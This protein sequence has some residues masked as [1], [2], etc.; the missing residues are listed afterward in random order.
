MKKI[1]ILLLLP[2]FGFGQVSTF[3]WVNDFES[4]VLLDE[5]QNDD[6]DWWLAQG[7][8]S[9][10]NTGP[11]G[12]HTTGNG[13]YYYVESSYPG[14]PNQ[15][16]ITY[17]PTFDISAT[18]G[19]VLS[20]WYHMYGDAM[21]DLEIAVI[22]G[23]VYTPIDTISGNQGDQW[24][25]AYYPITAIDSFKIAFK[26]TTGA[27]FTSDICIDDL[28]VSDPYTII[29]GCMDTISSNY[30]STATINVGCIY[31]YGCVDPLA[32]NY[33]PW[34]NVNDGSCTQVVACSPNK[35]LVDIA[36]TLDNW[37]N[38]TSWLIYSATDTFAQVPT[39]TYDYTQTGQT[40]HT[41]VCI[42]VGDS[43]MFTLNDS[44]GD[45]IGGGSVVGGCLVTNLDCED[46]IF[47]LNPPNFGYT[48]SSNPYVSAACNNDTTIYG[49][50][51]ASYLEYDPLATDDDG[52]CLTFATYGCTDVNAYNYDPWADRML[53]TSPCTYDLILYD[54]GG[55]SWGACWLGVEQGDSLWQFKINGNGIYSQTFALTLNSYDEV[56]MYYF[57]I[58]TPQQNAQQLDIQTIQ[59]SFKL[60]NS[61]GIILYEGNNP[62]P[63]PNE[64]KLRNYKGALDI[65]S[66][67]PYCG[68]ECIP[69]IIGCMDVMAFNYNNLA[70]TNDTCYYNPGCTNVG[71]LEYYTQGFVADVDDGSC[72]TVAVFG[73]TDALA[74]NYDLLAN[75]DNGGCIP[76]ILG[77]M[78][79]LAFNYNPQANTSDTCIAIVYG[80][81]SSI[82]INYDP[83]ANMDDGSCIG[84][85]Y[86]CTDST[87]WNYSPSANADDGSCVSYIYGCMD[88]TMWNYNP[89]ANTDN[90]ACITFVYGC[91]DSTMFNYNPLANTNNDNCIPFI[92]GCTNPIALNYD[93]SANTDDFSCILSIYG[94][95]DSLAF[96]YNP[97][98]NVDNN[99]C[100]PVILGCT[101]PIALNYCDS[102]NTDDFSCVLPIYGCTDS[103]MF[104]YNPLAN[105]DNSSCVPFI[106][107]CT[108]P[109]M[110]NYNSLANTE[111]FSCISYIYGCMD[112]TALNYDSLANTDNESCITIVE[113]CMDQSAYNYDVTA[114]VSDSISCLFDAGCITGAGYPYWLNDPCYA[115]VVDIDDYCCENEWDDICQLTYDYCDGTYIGPLLKRTENEKELIMI[116]DLLGRP[117]KE[118]KNQLLFYIYDDGSVEKTI[119]K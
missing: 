42:P 14:Y 86:G 25:F 43:I 83:L 101:D 21:G 38:E 110:L 3:P 116:T 87:M 37:P 22:S 23:G 74:F 28:M 50:T 114:N 104:N 69:V 71:Y 92:Y 105:V 10:S 57:E 9:S 49:C 66:A 27:S 29:Y 78:Q 56:Y 7:P 73:C 119:K 77:C 34:A 4:Y 33:N 58:A 65:Y 93:A 68:D 35:S 72:N 40:I 54:D 85:T 96:N 52:S 112:S 11:S 111:D 98:A 109:S 82:A 20:F 31:Y 75:V 64:N 45:G 67:Q 36:I 5:D 100:L 53:L 32:T 17:T 76:V 91:V 115:W 55:D 60:E 106:F 16:F 61:Y 1:L 118:I 63:G 70:N 113:G 108:D 62:W 12:D 59:N 6:G 8:T 2:I 103:V 117:T 88:A 102:C 97:L 99:S 89:L 95:M 80:C 15:T 18:P 84:V 44:Y 30:D 48:A 51:N 79:P 90:G 26:A 41:K 24:Y 81:M 13:I 19:K 94:C 39:N 46:T 107:G 47:L